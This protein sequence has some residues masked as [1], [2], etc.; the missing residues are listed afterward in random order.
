MGEAVGVE[1]ERAAQ[2]LVGAE[3]VVPRPQKD[4]LARHDDLLQP[5][6]EAV[7]VRVQGVLTARRVVDL[8]DL[9]GL[10]ELT[11]QGEGRR[12]GEQHRVRQ[13]AAPRREHRELPV[14]VAVLRPHRDDGVLGRARRGLYR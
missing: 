8:S 14:H 9:V 5:V 2:D 13:V 3:H 4:A 1:I 12:P 11:R 7:A 6:I 10:V